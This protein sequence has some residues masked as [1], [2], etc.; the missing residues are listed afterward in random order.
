[1]Y[2]VLVFVF[3]GPYCWC[4]IGF[5]TFLKED[6]LLQ[7]VGCAC[8][9]KC[10]LMFGTHPSRLHSRAAVNPPLDHPAFK[11]SKV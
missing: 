11:H 6:H 9:K 3:F 1:M 5:S 4:C 7:G 10:A 8:D 2:F